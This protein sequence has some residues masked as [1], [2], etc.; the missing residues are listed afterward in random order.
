VSFQLRRRWD[1]E[2]D[3]L[4]GV[5]GVVGDDGSDEEDMEG[6]PEEEREA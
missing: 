2:A 6:R 3:E 4:L 5:T 1:D